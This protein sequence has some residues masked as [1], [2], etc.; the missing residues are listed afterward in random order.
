MVQAVCWNSAIVLLFSNFSNTYKPSIGATAWRVTLPETNSNF[1]RENRQNHP[2][3]SYSNHPVSGAN[4][5]FQ[6]GYLQKIKHRSVCLYSTNSKFS[7]RLNMIRRRQ[8]W[9]NGTATC[10]E[11]CGYPS[12]DTCF[13]GDWGPKR[14]VFPIFF[15]NVSKNPGIFFGL[16]T[17]FWATI[18]YQNWRG[19]SGFPPS[20]QTANKKFGGYP[21]PQNYHRLDIP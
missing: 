8:G 12:C 15:S 10:N 16:Q 11:G 21:L 18:F 3:W 5:W 9:Q 7:R 20:F 14:C 6:G 13:E 17:G 4:C 19:F 2:K 1:A